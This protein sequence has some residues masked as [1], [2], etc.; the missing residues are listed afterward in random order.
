MRLLVTRESEVNMLC[1]G[2]SYLEDVTLNLWLGVMALLR[3][4]S[5]MDVQ[6]TQHYKTLSTLT[7]LNYSSYVINYFPDVCRAYLIWLESFLQNWCLLG[8]KMS[9]GWTAGGL[10]SK[11][12]EISLKEHHFILWVLIVK[13]LFFF[14]NQ[15]ENNAKETVKCCK[16]GPSSNNSLTN[17]IR[18]GC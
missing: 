12:L 15:I 11:K 5:W 8:H 13:V 1:F 3:Y 7:A 16:T 17:Q 9:Q 10:Y 18:L 2:S 6:F 14:L 4:I